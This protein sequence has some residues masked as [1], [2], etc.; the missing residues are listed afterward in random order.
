MLYRYLG[1]LGSNPPVSFV[2]GDLL[3]Y[4]T[5]AA[6]LVA[7]GLCL[8]KRVPGRRTFVILCFV[9]YVSMILEVT[10]FPVPI[11][12]AEI[13]RVRS[14]PSLYVSPDL[15]LIPFHSIAASVA[16]AESQGLA[17]FIRNWLGNL[18]LLMPLGFMAPIIWKRFRRAS[19][20][21]LLCLATSLSIE[22]VQYVGSFL[23]FTI[24]WKSVDVDDVI[25]NVVGGLLG[26][27]LFTLLRFASPATTILSW[28]RMGPGGSRGLQNR[29][30]A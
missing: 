13:A 3:Y 18:L 29:S 6:L 9:L 8:W 14:D 16:G 27:L 17:V 21:V 26:F 25:V 5:I 20:T 30:G 2:T 4:P 28:R 24:R 12:L 1:I 23:V 10:L 22:F 19:R 15:N 7:S 11:S